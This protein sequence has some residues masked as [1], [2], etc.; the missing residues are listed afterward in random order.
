MENKNKPMQ[1]VGTIFKNSITLKLITVTILM[2]LLLIPTSMIKSI[3]TER[4]ELN[5]AATEEVSSKWANEQLL[6]G[7]ILSIP[8][9][10]EY[11]TNGEKKS[12]I[13]MLNILPDELNIN[14][15][16]NPQNLKRGIYKIIVYQSEINISG[17]FRITGDFDVKGLTEIQYDKAFISMGISDLRGIKSQLN[18]NWDSKELEVIPGS[19][20]PDLISSGVTFAIP[21]LKEKA[22][23][24]IPFS[25]KLNLQGSKN[26]SFVPIGNHTKVNI[27]S[28]WNS[29]SFDGSF[30]PDSRSISETGFDAEWTILQLNRNY[31]QQ[32]IGQGYP[33]QMNSS[34]FGINFLKPLDDYQKSFRS[35]KYAAMTIALTFLIFFLV[36][37][38]NKRKIHPFQYGLVGLALC[39]F[40]IL[41]VSISEHSSFNFA[42]AVSALSVIVMI[43]LYSR[44]VFKK[45]KLSMVLAA[46]LIAIYG[47]LFVTLQLSDYALLLGSVGLM[48]ILGLTMYFTR[49]IDW[50][51]VTMD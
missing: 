34:S 51:E 27:S 45:M 37:V 1:T 6:N 46:T 3:I 40:Y 10:Y 26:L 42:Y 50:Y 5:Q 47:F 38:L 9:H 25:L 19:K 35:A 36:E 13:K 24:P 49:K 32:W 2:L 28:N 16:V 20:I 33:K 12:A 29:P 7:P 21:D 43:A 30:L 39:L 8:L 31:P 15:I 11:Q 41:L 22:N 4:E 14:G 44:N 23:K 48:V 18:L 17:Q